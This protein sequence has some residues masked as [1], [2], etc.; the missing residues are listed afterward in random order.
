MRKLI[1]IA[2]A[3]A[4][5]AVPSAAMAAGGPTTG[6][7]QGEPGNSAFGNWRAGTADGPGFAS[8]QHGEG[9]LGADA[10]MADYNAYVFDMVGFEGAKGLSK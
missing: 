8:W 6:P 5:L 7:V 2:S 4:A 1:I 3:V 9:W 10:T